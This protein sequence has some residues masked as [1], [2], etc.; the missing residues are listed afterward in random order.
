MKE[1]RDLTQGKIMTQLLLFAIPLFGSS[2]IQQLYNTVD[3]MFVG[4]ILGKEAAA[5]VG[6]SSLMVTLLLGLF[7]GL[8]VGTNVVT[9][10]AFGAKK[11]HV[12]GQ[13]IHT[14][15]GL[16]LI[17]SLGLLV[18]GWFLAPMFLQWMNTPR[19]IHKLAVLYIRIYFLSL[20]FIISYNMGAGV[21]R[22]MGDSKTPMVYQLIGGV[23]N[24]IGNAFFIVVMDMGV[25][26]IALST[27][28]SQGIPAVLV[29]RQMC[30]TDERY[31]LKWNKIRCELPIVKEVLTIGIPAAVQAMVITLSNLIV[32]SQINSLGVESIAAFTA[33]FKIENFIY[34]P[35]LAL[36]Q[37]ISTFV[38]QNVGAGKISRVK[39][40]ISYT[41]LFGVGMTILISA[42]IL[43][44]AKPI[45]GLFANEG[46]V[47]ELG[48]AIAKVTFPFYF[49]YVFLEVFAS[50][51]RGTGKSI[52]PM[53]I[54]LFNMCGVRLVLL[55][56]IMQQ[57]HSATA[58]ALIYP[59][60]WGTTGLCL[61]LY[62]R[63][64]I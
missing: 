27:L 19:E 18:I 10:K 13:I 32:Q 16:S 7:T 35:I 60:T 21:L 47:I 17:G 12:L 52:P 28:F 25:G 3:L 20:P 40:G 1:T 42:G 41:L 24:V 6:A 29:V 50:S 14:T 39:K 61:Y 57:F 44:V 9:A 5:A 46:N 64:C 45:Y 58:V 38:G 15:A 23:V 62:T 63:R 48:I 59:I 51:L 54:I 56:M 43:G 26:G 37:A 55:I 33:Y 30:M 53:V 8:S 34:L 49:L 2:L 31:R 4:K 36:G 11:K 22:A